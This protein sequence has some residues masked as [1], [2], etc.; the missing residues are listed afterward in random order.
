MSYNVENNLPYWYL[1]GIVSFGPT[2][3]GT[4]NIPGVYTRVSSYLE[5]LSEHIKN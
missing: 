2:K 3:C 1:V 4:K 5:W